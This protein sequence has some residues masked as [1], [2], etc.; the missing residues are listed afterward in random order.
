MSRRKGT[1]PEQFAGAFQRYSEIPPRYRLETYAGQYQ[2]QDTWTSY[3]DD[4]LFEE[5]DSKHMR[6]AA[7]K[8]GGS[9]LTHMEKQGRHHA[10]ATPQ[11][12]DAWCQKLLDGD[13]VRRTCYEHYFVRIYQFYD[14]LKQN[15]QP[16]HLY[17][18]LLLAAIE[19]D[20]ARHLW[21]FRIDTRP[22]AVSRE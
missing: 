19:Y 4:V 17:N 11:H 22:E 14:Y 21:M 20:T 2:D 5:H 12:A 1:K 16:P 7:R 15:H 3:C 8:A 13:R 9:W 10:L 18:P 6:Q